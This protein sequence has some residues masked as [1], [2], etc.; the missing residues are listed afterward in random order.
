MTFTDVKTCFLANRG[1]A[2]DLPWQDARQLSPAE[3]RTV[4]AS[5]QTFQRGEGTGGDHLLDLAAQWSATDYP[6]AM[7]LFIQEEEGHAAMLEQLLDHLRR[8]PNRPVPPG[9]GRVRT[10]KPRWRSSNKAA[11]RFL[12]TR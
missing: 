6:A 2:A 3:Q 5:L 11:P 4:R 7:Q 8:V 1:S 12:P 10:R 9:P